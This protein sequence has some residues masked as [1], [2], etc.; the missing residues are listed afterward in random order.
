MLGMGG[1]SG[2]VKADGTFELKG[3]T[4]TRLIRAVGLPPGWMLKSV[5]VNGADVTDTGV[6]F[7]PG[8]AV[9]G[10][11]V[12]VDVEGHRRV[13]HRQGDATDNR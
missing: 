7:K 9:T 6:E 8:E 12:V 11:E 1:G 5:H 4:G 13:G 3:L 10:L 2:T